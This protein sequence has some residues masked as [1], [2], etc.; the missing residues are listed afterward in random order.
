M[1]TLKRKRG[2]FGGGP[3]GV[4]MKKARRAGPIRRAAVAGELKF[5]D[6]DLDDAL[7]SATGTVT[8]SINLIAQ[9]VLENTRVGRKCT[10]KNIQKHL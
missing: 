2:P 1:S 8:P 5:H 10:L 6:V 4:P 3:S 9:D 7:V